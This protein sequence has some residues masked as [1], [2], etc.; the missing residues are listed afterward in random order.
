MDC[1]GF[2]PWEKPIECKQVFKTKHNLDG[3]I[4]CFKARFVDKGYTQVDGLDFHKTFT[5]VENLVKG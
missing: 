3:S 2:T 5:L 4:E 1:W